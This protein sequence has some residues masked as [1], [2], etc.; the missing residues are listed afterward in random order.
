MRSL[1]SRVDEI[2]GERRRLEKVVAIMRKV[3]QGSGT[4]RAL[5]SLA[6]FRRYLDAEQSL[7]LKTDADAAP[8]AS[9][10]SDVNDSSR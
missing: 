7:R 6:S 2:N 5:A 8:P 9:D 10:G 4:H 1:K 3:R